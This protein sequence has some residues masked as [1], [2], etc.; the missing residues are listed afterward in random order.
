[1]SDGALIENSFITAVGDLARGMY[2]VG[3]GSSVT[4]R[5][6]KVAEAYLKKFKE[7]PATSYYQSGYDAVELLLRAIERTTVSRADGLVSIGREA[8]RRQLYQTKNFDGITGTL[9]CDQFGD[10]AYPVFHVLRL[11]NPQ[12]GVEGLQKNVQFTFTPFM[13]GKTIGKEV[14]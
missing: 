7:K 14:Q 3:P 6:K 10:C 2:F 13:K 1:M 5:S 8:L 12:Q 11:D 9:S 4:T